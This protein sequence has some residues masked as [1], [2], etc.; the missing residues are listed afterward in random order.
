MPDAPGRPVLVV[1]AFPPVPGPVTAVT[2]A[3]VRRYVAEGLTV[4][5]AAVRP[6]GAEIVVAAT[7]PL[8]G[9]ALTHLGARTGA[10]RLVFALDEGVPARRPRPGVAGWVDRGAAAVAVR[11]LARAFGHFD[12]VTVLV[13]GEVGLGSRILSPLWAV[14]RSVVV[15]G[16]PALAAGLGVPPAR[17]EVVAAPPS[18]RGLVAD[19][20]TP[21]GPAEVTPVAM[22]RYVLGRAGRR[23]LGPR[24]MPVYTRVLVTQNRARNVVARVRSLRR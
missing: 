16:P 8:A 21:R 20:V 18:L 24:F 3:T 12:D 1:G 19:G 4:R 6:G 22:P 13:A 7:G 5:T 10:R 15:A 11:S 2:L 9:R 14:S 23:V 17:L